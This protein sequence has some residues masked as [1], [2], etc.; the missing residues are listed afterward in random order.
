[1]LTAGGEWVEPDPQLLELA[2]E[3]D[4]VVFGR[5]VEADDLA[6]RVAAV[7]GDGWEPPPM[8]LHP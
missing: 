1:M 5:R 7:L 3:C 6:D 4:A 8:G 2:V